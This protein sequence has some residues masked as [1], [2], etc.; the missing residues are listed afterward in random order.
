VSILVQHVGHVGHACVQT[1]H[2]CYFYIILFVFSVSF[3]RQAANVAN[4][5]YYHIPRRSACSI[6]NKIANLFGFYMYSFIKIL[7]DEE[8]VIKIFRK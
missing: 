8:L 2:Y 6:N 5:L 1:L 7:D 4:K 3:T